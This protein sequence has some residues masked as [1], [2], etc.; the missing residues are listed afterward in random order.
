MNDNPSR[1]RTGLPHIRPRCPDILWQEQLLLESM[2][3][4]V[5]GI[6]SDHLSDKCRMS[7]YQTGRLALWILM[8]TSPLPSCKDHPSYM[9]THSRSGLSA[10]LSALLRCA[11]PLFVFAFSYAL[12][13]FLSFPFSL[14]LSY[15]PTNVRL[16]PPEG[17]A[18]ACW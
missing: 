13:S 4:I 15:S 18:L 9:M 6:S 11:W 2:E 1:E 7:L 10:L 16:G 3:W 14:P 5:I 8:D 12:C 17:A